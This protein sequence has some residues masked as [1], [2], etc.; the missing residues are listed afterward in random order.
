MSEL[1]ARKLQERTLQD[2]VLAAHREVAIRLGHFRPANARE[3]GQRAFGPCGVSELD[4][5]KELANG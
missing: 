2:F 5:V 3:R 4:C 1:E